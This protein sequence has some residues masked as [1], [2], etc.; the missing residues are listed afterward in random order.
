MGPPEAGPAIAARQAQSHRITQE[1][2]DTT[3]SWVKDGGK[4]ER[5]LNQSANSGVER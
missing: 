5:G 3:V 1:T 2:A 4:I